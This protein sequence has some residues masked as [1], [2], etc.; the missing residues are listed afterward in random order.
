M[1]YHVLYGLF[2]LLLE[3]IYWLIH[4]DRINLVQLREV[5]YKKIF[6]LQRHR[7]M[8][9]CKKKPWSVELPSTF[10]SSTF[11]VIS[12]LAI[13]IYIVAVVGSCT[14]VLV[15]FATSRVLRLWK[16]RGHDHKVSRTGSGVLSKFRVIVFVCYTPIRH[17]P[18]H[19]KAPKIQT[20]QFDPYE[21][22]SFFLFPSGIWFAM[23]VIVRFGIM[24]NK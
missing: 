6:Y 5:R 2:L 9:C 4:S 13:V 11:H 22:N 16:S 3:V 7:H 19:S 23:N 12:T 20:L 14:W 10:T 15:S 1:Q 24:E 8:S 21:K 17:W 18:E